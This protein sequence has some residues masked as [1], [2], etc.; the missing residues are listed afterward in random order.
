MSKNIL[1]V[2]EGEQEKEIFNTFI[3]KI[4]INDFSVCC[5][6]CTTI[7]QLYREIKDD[8]DL[9]LFVLLKDIEGNRE[10]LEGY[11]RD[12]FAEIYLFFDYDGHAP[13]ASDNDLDSIIDLFSE[14][15]DHGKIYINYPMVESLKHYNPKQF[16]FSELTT[17]IQLPKGTSYKGI[18]NSQC[19]H[20]LKK[21]ENFGYK[22]WQIVVDIHLK[23]ANLLV[24][25][26]YSMPTYMVGQKEIFECQ[27]LSYI[28]PNNE[29]FILNSFPLFLFEY[30]G[31]DVITKFL[32]TI[33]R[34]EYELN[35]L[36]TKELIEVKNNLIQIL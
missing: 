32:K 18:V 22:Q 5:A 6:Y 14:E 29:V 26:E 19:L 12:D 17:S 2:F 25:G 11:L 3:S 15:T 20:E 9:D 1:F 23:K 13:I 28:D 31:F 8:E 7:Y 21:L 27:R 35:K 33:S 10:V 24:N 34:F 36:T 16:K 30:H 4:K